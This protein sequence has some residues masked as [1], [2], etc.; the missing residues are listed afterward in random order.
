MSYT[1]K[2]IEGLYRK[3]YYHTAAS[4]QSFAAFSFILLHISTQ[5]VIF[6]IR[7]GE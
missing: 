2:N 4:E 6:A 3:P 7:K 5:R 1:P